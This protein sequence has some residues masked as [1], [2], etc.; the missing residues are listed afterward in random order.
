[1]KDTDISSCLILLEDIDI[2][3]LGKG[4]SCRNFA[5]VVGFFLRHT[6]EDR[7]LTI[8]AVCSNTL[9]T[10]SV[11]IFAASRQITVEK[12]DVALL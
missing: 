10:P 11:R 9:I 3:C 6:T 4:N 7:P 5:A 8:P 12:G 2:E 1:M